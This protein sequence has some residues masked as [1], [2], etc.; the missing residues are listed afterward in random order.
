M[1]VEGEEEVG[2]RNLL[3]FFKQYRKRLQSDVIVVCDTENIETG[4]PSITYSLRGIV[5]V[6]VDVESATKPVHSGA[7]GGALA[8]AAIALNVILARLYWKNGKLPIPG[9]YDKVRKLTGKERN[10]I[11]KLP[12][13]EASSLSLLD[14]ATGKETHKL[15]FEVSGRYEMRFRI[16]MR[17]NA[18]GR[19]DGDEREE[20]VVAYSPDGKHLA[21]LAGEK[22]ALAASVWHRPVPPAAEQER[23]ASRQGT[24]GATLLQG[25]E[26]EI[27]IAASPRKLTAGATLQVSI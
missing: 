24:A 14:A 25:N 26:M 12:G 22:G 17:M 16:R 23:L 27:R 7:A 9:Y 1:L 18:G 20:G 2:S 11:K 3:G 4:L 5:A 8:D 6:R 10:T 21:L 13:D 15:K 19:W